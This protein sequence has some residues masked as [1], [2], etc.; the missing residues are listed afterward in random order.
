MEQGKLKLKGKYRFRCFSPD[1]KL[2]WEDTIENIVVNTG[3]TFALNVILGSQAKMG[4]WYVGLTDSAPTVAPTDT[5]ASHPGWT[6]VV[7]YEEDTR[8]G[9][10]VANTVN[11]SI[12]NAATPARFIVNADSTVIGGAFVVSNAAKNGAAGTLFS[13]AA[14]S[15]GDKT[16]NNG[17]T[18]E[19]DY[20][21]AA[22]DA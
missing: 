22:S 7:A 4:A 9:L 14:F 17:E 15:T 10:N 13:V 11:Q 2:L 19:V 6:E 12:T 16:V 3:L 1:G 18:L 21:L 20:T 5:I 8:Q